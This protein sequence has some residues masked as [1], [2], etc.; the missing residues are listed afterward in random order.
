[1]SYMY[2]KQTYREQKRIG[3]RPPIPEVQC[4][5]LDVWDAAYNRHLQAGIISDLWIGGGAEG[6]IRPAASYRMKA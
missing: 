3:N 6:E 1:M 5:G 4:Q 2:C